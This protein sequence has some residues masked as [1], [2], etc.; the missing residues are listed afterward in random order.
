MSGVGFSS[1][2]LNRLIFDF[3]A[4]GDDDIEP[5]SALN[6]MEKFSFRDIISFN[7]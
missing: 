6:S 2:S 4:F 3:T 7:S 1:Q 5:C